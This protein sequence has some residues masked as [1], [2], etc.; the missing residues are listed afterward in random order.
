M[1]GNGDYLNRRNQKTQFGLEPSP[2]NPQPK[3]ANSL[4]GRDRGNIGTP[5]NNYMIQCED[6]R[7]PFDS[8]DKDKSVGFEHSS[9]E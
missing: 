7:F 6:I 3:P 2:N 8:S 9:N 1:F 4:D 5:S